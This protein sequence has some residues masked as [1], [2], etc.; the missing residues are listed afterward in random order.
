MR[1]V[2]TSVVATSLLNLEFSGVV[3]SLPGKIYELN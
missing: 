3:R 1:L 2:A